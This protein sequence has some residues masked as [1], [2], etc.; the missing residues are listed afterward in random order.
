MH[1]KLQALFAERDKPKHCGRADAQAA[2]APL[3]RHAAALQRQLAEYRA[4]ILEAE[5]APD[6]HPLFAG[7]L[8]FLHQT[9]AAGERAAAEVMRVGRETVA[10]HNQLA[11]IL[12]DAE[13]DVKA[14][15]ERLKKL[16]KVAERQGALPPAVP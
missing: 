8:E 6:L 16:M 7:K 13:E 3:I 12:N 15:G 10:I 1:E 9:L 14:D 4:L 11:R 5:L 2:A